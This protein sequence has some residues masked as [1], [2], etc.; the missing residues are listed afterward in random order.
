MCKMHRLGET[1]QL[2]NAKCGDE[3]L[4]RMQLKDRAIEWTSAIGYGLVIH[5]IVNRWMILTLI[6]FN[7]HPLCVCF[8]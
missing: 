7:S 3:T 5:E 8:F 4:G 1:R 6:V 2:S